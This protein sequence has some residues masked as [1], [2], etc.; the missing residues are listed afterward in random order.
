[1]VKTFKFY[2]S[3]LINIFLTFDPR[4]KIVFFPCRYDFV[5]LKHQY[6]IVNISS[7]VLKRFRDQK[8][9]NKKYVRNHLKSQHIDNNEIGNKKKT[10]IIKK[11]PSDL[12]KGKNTKNH[13]RWQ[14]NE[15]L[16]KKKWKWSMVVVLAR[17]L[18]YNLCLFYINHSS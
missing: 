13:T 3:F 9:K 7:V 11:K 10:K 18:F 2:I 17:N 6:P 12:V 8:R 14:E 4:K 15:C 5:N 1:M 16:W